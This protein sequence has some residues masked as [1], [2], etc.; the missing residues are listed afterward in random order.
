[1]RLKGS[2]QKGTGAWM[3]NAEAGREQVDEA[4]SLRRL[5]CE[6][7]DTFSFW[8]MMTLHDASPKYALSLGQ[9]RE[10]APAF[11]L[12]SVVGSNHPEII[13]VRSLSYGAACQHCLAY[14]NIKMGKRIKVSLSRI[15]S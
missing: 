10:D 1:M 2:G 13:G 8:Q 12:G 4:V 9:H 7:L 11:L 3:R 6:L 15:R 14:P 5:S